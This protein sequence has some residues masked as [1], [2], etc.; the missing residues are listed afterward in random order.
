MLHFADQN[1]PAT[2]QV[3]LAVLSHAM[4]LC[5][6]KVVVVGIFGEYPVLPFSG[7]IETLVAT[8]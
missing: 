6:L 4:W 2:Q 3:P 5:S 7:S 1:I 8:H